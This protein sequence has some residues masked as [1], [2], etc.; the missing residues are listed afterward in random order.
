MSSNTGG[1][2]AQ[3][4]EDRIEPSL[5]YHTAGNEVASAMRKWFLGYIVLSADG[6][7]YVVN[8][9]EVN[10]LKRSVVLADVGSYVVNGQNAGLYVYRIPI[11]IFTAIGGKI[12]FKAIDDKFYLE[13]R[14]NNDNEF[15]LRAT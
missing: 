9:A 11:A 6:G 14:D 3:F 2:L 4:G 13:A 1:F 5:F 15:Y 10:L 7:S 12:Y 8:G